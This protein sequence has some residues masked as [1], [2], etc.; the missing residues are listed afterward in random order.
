VTKDSKRQGDP[1]IPEVPYLRVANAQRAWLDLA[2]VTKIRVAEKVVEK[3]R[4]R[5]GDL[6]MAEGG[7]RDKLGRGWIWEDQLPDCIH[8]NHLFR[9]RL[10][11]DAT[12]PKLLAWYVNSAARAWFESN[13]KQSVNLASISISK[14]KQLPV[15]TPPP[16]SQVAAVK[17]GEQALARLAQLTEHCR[18]AL[19]HNTALRRALLADAFAGRLVPQDSADEPAEE[20]LKRIRVEREAIEA[21]KKAIRRAARAR[22]KPDSRPTTA[23]PPPAHTTS[24]VDAI[25][26]QATLPLEFSA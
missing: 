10:R 6:L 16:E 9:A 14:V 13:G 5:E 22:A 18:T 26:E 23:P 15:P 17:A 24:A 21:E 8:Q 11:D 1:D 19:A 2:H 25:G 3:L 4:L 7:D 20:V 12:H